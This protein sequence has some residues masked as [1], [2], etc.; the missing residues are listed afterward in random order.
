MRS[1]Q[2]IREELGLSQQ[3]LADY[4]GVS[5]SLIA[6]SETGRRQ[7]P[8]DVL[9]RIFPLMETR[10]DQQDATKQRVTESVKH[11]WLEQELHLR[12]HRLQALR[13]RHDR[14]QRQRAAQRRTRRLLEVDS[15]SAKLIQRMQRKAARRK[16]QL[17]PEA[18]LK[19]E[20]RI[21]ALEAEVKVLK[22]WLR[23]REDS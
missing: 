21:A 7:L 10:A 23:E 13:E 12:Q 1:L 8:F 20:L 18:C 15:Q 6:L 2:T 4:L 16:D 11:Q 3:E 5:R 22:R 19:R 17:S 9:Q 14:C